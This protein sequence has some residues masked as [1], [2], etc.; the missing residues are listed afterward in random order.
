MHTVHIQRYSAS[1][2]FLSL[3]IVCLCLIGCDRKPQDANA[4]EQDLQQRSLLDEALPLTQDKQASAH[5]KP[6]PRQHN[7]FLDMVS[8][9]RPPRE[10]HLHCV[11]VNNAPI[12]DGIG[13][14]EAWAMATPIQT[15][16]YSSQR[17][18]TISAVHDSTRIYLRVSYPDQAPSI[19]HKSWYWNESESYYMQGMD[20][21][22]MFVI[23]WSMQGLDAKIALRDA[24]AHVAD[25]W[26]WKAC[27]TNPVGYW[28]DKRHE[29]TVEKTDKSLKLTAA[30]GRIGYLRR[31]GDQGKQA[32]VEVFPSSFVESCLPRYS[33]SMPTQSRADVQGKGVW[34]KG[35]WTLEC[36]R[37]LKTGHDDDLQFEPGQQYL[38]GV[39]CY[40][41]AGTGV[42]QEFSQPLYRTGDVFDRL[43]LVIE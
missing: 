17:V 16:D 41:M 31:I 12:I 9:T 3:A 10:L 29:V 42:N 8:P 4:T 25:I 22:D 11:K 7:E 18:L 5:F 15:L 27:R 14:D 1:G 34:Q 30:D 33:T 43:I 32:Y 40:E 24:T 23:K 19:T 35:Q 6:S 26:F 20:R 13:V 39:G 37:L 2:V 28:D 38:F 36:Q 21:E